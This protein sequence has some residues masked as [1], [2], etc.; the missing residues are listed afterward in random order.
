METRPEVIVFPDGRM[1]PVVRMNT[2]HWVIYDRPAGV[3]LSISKD[4]ARPARLDE[5][6]A[7]YASHV[8]KDW[9]RQE[10]VLRRIEVQ[11]L[12]MKR[13]MLDRGV[14]PA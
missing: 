10:M 3:N 7:Y 8:P 2:S 9:Q 1:V 5:L 6:V 14:D 4:D 11:A 12:W 13:G